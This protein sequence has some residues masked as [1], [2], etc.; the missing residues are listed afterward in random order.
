MTSTQDRQ[1]WFAKRH[2]A[3]L[4]LMANFPLAFFNGVKPLKVGI[5]QDIFNANQEGMPAKRWVKYALKHYVTSHT[6]LSGL[7]AGA[8]RFDLQGMPHGLV[9]EQ[10]AIN[11]KALRLRMD[12]KMNSRP[13]KTQRV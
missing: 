13:P 10:E 4:W 12:K 2:E 9:S 11:A 3:L 6:Y 1:S 5:H 7:E 8:V